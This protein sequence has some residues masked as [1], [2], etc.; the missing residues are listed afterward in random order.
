MMTKLKCVIEVTL[1]D[2]EEPDSPQLLFLNR[3]HR[4]SQ[5]LDF[6][7][8]ISPKVGFEFFY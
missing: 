5:F 4:N 1:K 8:D 3:F 6:N 7:Q 2:V